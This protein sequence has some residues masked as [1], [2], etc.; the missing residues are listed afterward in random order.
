MENFLFSYEKIDKRKTFSVT[1]DGIVYIYATLDK[2]VKNADQVWAKVRAG[3]NLLKATSLPSGVL[4]IVVADDFGATSSLLL[5]IESAG[6]S[7]RELEE[8][9]KQICATLRTIPEMG[10]LKVLGKKTEEIAVEID[11]NQLSRYGVDHKS[12]LADLALQGFRTVSGTMGKKG[13]FASMQVEIPYRTEYEIGEQVVYT[14]PLDGS[15]LRLKDIATITRR[16]PKDT[17]V[18]DYY[19]GDEKANCVLI[20]IEMQPGHNIVEFGE[21]VDR[22]LEE[23]SHRLPPDVKQHR[24][25]DMPKVVDQSVHSFMRDILFSVAVVIGVML[26]LFPLKT[27]LVA[28]LGVPVCAIITFGVMY[29]TGIE[30]NTVTLAALIVV[31]GMIVDNS[32]IVVDGYTNMLERG[33]SRWYSAAV[34]TKEQFIAMLIA[35]LSI[36]GMFFPMIKIITGVLGEFV[37]LCPLAV[38]IALGISIFYAVYVTPYLATVFIKRQTGKPSF[39]ERLQDGI[40][41]GLQRIYE[42]SLRLCFRHPWLTIL[43][44]LGFVGLGGFLF[45]KLNVQLMPKAER[46]CFVVEIHLKEGSSIAETAEVCDSLA[47]ILI[48]DERVTNITSFVGQASPRFHASFVPQMGGDNFAQFIVNTVSNDATVEIL[49]DYTTRY[50]NHFK[51]AYIHF[52]QMDYQAVYNPVEIY[53]KGDDFSVLEPIADS[54]KN[55]MATMPEL[56]WVHTDYEQCRQQVRIRLKEDEA[57][58]LGISQTMLSLYLSQAFGGQTLTTIWEGDYGVPV[59]LYSAN[60]DSLD[61]NA[62]GDMLVPVAAPSV[63]VTLAQVADLEPAYHHANIGRRNSIRTISVCADL[64]E[65]EPYG[66][67]QQKID[68]WVKTHLADLPEGV[69]IENGGL[70]TGNSETVPEMA[71]FVAAALLVMFVVLLYHFGKISLSVLTLASSILCLFGSIFGLYLFRL[72]FSITAVLGV[73]SLIGI[74]VRN[75]IMMYEYAE[76]LRR[77]QHL[78]VRQAAFDSGVRRMRPVFLTSATTALGVIPMIVAHTSLWMPMGV[79]ICFGTIF[80]LPL[81]LTVLPVAYWKVFNHQDKKQ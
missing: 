73:V 38:F 31:L 67:A 61:Y 71:L 6:H 32:V 35:T 64:G 49:H 34:S 9:S 53:V 77:E 43:T 62:L 66:K 22:A 17:K 47:H 42:A 80:T 4:Q 78:S 19:A 39:M 57:E 3:L 48:A 30:L 27:A 54:L 72:D 68:R 81:A 76:Q 41:S 55:Y 69:T 26:L 36:S 28:G 52:K 59:I 8:Y 70:G 11:L 74:I 60:I 15:T 50:E 75:A 14:N 40:F 33:Y 51:N 45:T 12:L 18:V 37:Q 46:D 58:R 7:P 79:V 65:G 1:K 2:S 44:A 24:I 56:H 10:K 21:K 16:Y 25:T 20:S 5:A 63:W 29:L 13:N 23:V